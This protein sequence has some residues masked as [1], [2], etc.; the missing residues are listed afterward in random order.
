M[1]GLPSEI[2]DSDSHV[3]LL[4]SLTDV[5]EIEMAIKH[6]KWIKLNSS[7]KFQTVLTELIASLSTAPKL[8]PVIHFLQVMHMEGLVSKDDPW[9]KMLE[10]Y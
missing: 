7:F 9:M 3:I 6:I 8:E 1:H 10:G 4:K 2:E 5:G